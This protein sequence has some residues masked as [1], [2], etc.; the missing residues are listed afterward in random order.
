MHAAAEAAAIDGAPHADV[1]CEPTS[2]AMTTRA[3]VEH[4]ADL[5]ENLADL[6]QAPAQC[7]SIRT[8]SV[9]SHG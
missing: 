6:D 3:G 2:T 4:V 7:T 1:T 5:A 9:A 8:R